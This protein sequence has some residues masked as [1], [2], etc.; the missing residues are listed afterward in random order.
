MPRPKKKSQPEPSPAEQ[1]A[2]SRT[3]KGNSELATAFGITDAQ[4]R[5]LVRVESLPD[6][7][8][9]V[10]PG[11]PAPERETPLNIDEA[12][13]NIFREEAD[14]IRVRLARYGIAFDA[15]MQTEFCD[16]G[17]ALLTGMVGGGAI[18]RRR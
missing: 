7:P 12:V 13:A 2:R 3:M 4:P 15:R 16:H 8:E 14:E 17:M 11:A 6:P 18:G 10:A 9:T 5:E 1:A